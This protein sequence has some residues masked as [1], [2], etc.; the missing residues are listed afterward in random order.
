MLF[1]GL[2]EVF[3]RSQC[4]LEDPCGRASPRFRSEPDYEYDFVVVGGGSGGSVVA[5]RLSEI[6]QWKVLLIESGGDEPIGT[7]I[8]SMFLNF[9]GSDIDWKY[10]TEPEAKACLSSPEQRCYWPR[11]KVLGG[12]SV[13]NGMMYIRGNKQDFDDWE[14]M[15]NPGWKYDDVLPYF[16][17]SE[18]NMEINEVGTTYHA[19]GG[20]LPVGYGI[21]DLNGLNSTGFMIAQMTQSKGIR[22]SSA[23]SF[24]RPARNRTNFHILLNTTVTKILIVR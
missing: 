10:K 20:L 23:R 3:I 24:L 14:A 5:S 22:M 18:N 4:D 11:G 2:L 8:P 13:L 7:Q 19:T 12:T 21:H 6:D 9:L 16:K 1:M 17:M 15:G